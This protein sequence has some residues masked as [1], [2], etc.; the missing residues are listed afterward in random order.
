MVLNLLPLRGEVADSALSKFNLFRG[1]FTV[2]AKSI[3]A[4]DKLDF[5]ALESL[6]LN[7]IPL[8]RCREAFRGSR[9]SL[10]VLIS[11]SLLLLDEGLL[12]FLLLL[13]LLAHVD[14]V[15]NTCIKGFLEEA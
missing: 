11:T 6:G 1:E 2:L 3:E 13:L 8:S 4:N 7:F 10:T 14:V 12:L 5:F 9:L 15:D